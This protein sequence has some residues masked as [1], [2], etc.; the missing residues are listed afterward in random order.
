[1][2][3]FAFTVEFDGRPYMG[4]QRQA[5]GPS[6]Q[7]AIEDAIH[8]VTG[9]RVAVHAA[10]RTD[11]GVHGLAMRAHADV[12]K[13]ITPF[14][15]M[16]AIN[17]RLGRQPVAIL[18]C[19]EVADDWHARFSCM[20]RSYVYRIVNRRAALTFEAGLAWQVKQPLDAGAMHEAAQALV[21][22]HDFTTFRSAHC[23]SASPVKTLDRLSVEREGDRIAIH[24]AARSFLHHQVRSMV[25][26]L[27]YVGMGRWSADDLRDALAAADRSA[28][29]LNAPPDGLYFVRA[30]Y[31]A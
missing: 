22:L 20:G 31:P 28:L 13:A 11:T 30:D 25:G 10:G 16:E 17:A 7:Q 3:R 6:V 19:E 2:T 9:E 29:G 5:H 21:G 27:V 1:M 12:A 8:A 23:Q 26:C 4:W 14:R 24:A 18:A 15:L